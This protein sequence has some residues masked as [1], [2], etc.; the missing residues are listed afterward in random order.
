MD[1]TNFAQNMGQKYTFV[2]TVMNN[3]LP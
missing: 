1:W 2:K 3:R